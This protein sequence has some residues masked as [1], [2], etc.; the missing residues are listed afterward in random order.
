M[1]IDG[2]VKRRPGLE[3]FRH[4]SAMSSEGAPTVA[5]AESLGAYWIIL[6]AARRRRPTPTGLGLSGGLLAL[7]IHVCQIKSTIFLASTRS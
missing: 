6:K 2:R 7:K 1:N 4:C 3:T 5:S